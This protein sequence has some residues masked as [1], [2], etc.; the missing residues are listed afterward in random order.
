MDFSTPDLDMTAA[1]TRGADCH[2]EHPFTGV[3]LYF[4]EDEDREPVTIRI[5]GQDSREFRAMVSAA[6]NS[7]T[8]QKAFDV[9]S[10]EARAVDLLSGLVTG[11]RGIEWDGK[12][13]DCTRE[14]VRMLLL[15]FPPIR[16][17]LDAFIADR[18]NFFKGRAKN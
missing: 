6:A 18:A 9:D 16:T 17:Q 1:S 11:W 12:P 14:N 8:K 7:S 5:L 13:L 15:K 3:P 2:I 10:A 4:G